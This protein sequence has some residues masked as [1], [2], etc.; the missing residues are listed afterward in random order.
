MNRLDDQ[1]RSEFGKGLREEHDSEGRVREILKKG[2]I[3]TEDEYRLLSERADEIHQDA[4]KRDELARINQ[5][6][7][8]HDKPARQR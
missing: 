6:L 5:L 7:V 8:D 2:T 1:L 4:S 3:A